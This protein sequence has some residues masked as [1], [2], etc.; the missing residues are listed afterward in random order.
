MQRGLIAAAAAALLSLSIP[1]AAAK[2]PATWDG[3]VQVKSKRAD[4]VY[5]QPEADFRGYSK[6]MID[7]PEIA[8]RKNWQRDY[9][10][11]TVSLGGRISD[12]DVRKALDVATQGFATILADAYTKA[13]YQV[14]AAPGADVL[15]LSTAVIN[16]SVD[17]PDVMSAGR[18]RTYSQEA[19][20]ATLVVEARDS[21]SGAV[22]GRAVDGRVVGD[23]GIYLRTS[24]SNRADFEQLFRSWAKLSADGLNNLK[25][26]SPVDANG[27]LRK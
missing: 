15:R 27:Q 11:N 4:L 13:G 16:V 9:N 1:A 24:V 8:F 7:T 3:L 25:S 26:L 14:V 2:A 23:N 22:L 18:T 6:V 10:R 5:L 19:G 20:Q 12:E 21:V 17:A